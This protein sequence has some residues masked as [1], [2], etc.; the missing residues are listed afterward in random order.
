MFSF[1]IFCKLLIT[2]G[3]GIVF[4]RQGPT[5]KIRQFLRIPQRYSVLVHKIAGVRRKLPKHRFGP[6]NAVAMDGG[7]RVLGEAG[8][9]A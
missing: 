6:P 3:C 7:G 1:V 8:C 5:Q 4:R 2:N 9:R